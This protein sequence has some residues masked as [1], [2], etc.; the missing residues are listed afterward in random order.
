MKKTIITLA[1]VVLWVSISRGQ[2][3]LDT[4]GHR[5]GMGLMPE[6]TI[7]SMINGV[8]TGVRTLEMDVVISSDGQAVV[9]H[10]P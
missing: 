4:Q 1:G 2:Q 8:K 7:A 10:D 3:H 5:G 6:N 9:S